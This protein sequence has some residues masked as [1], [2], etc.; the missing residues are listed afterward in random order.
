MVG[1]GSRILH[2]RRTWR[3]SIPARL[4]AHSTLAGS[5]WLRGREEE[6]KEEEKER[7][8]EERMESIESNW[9]GLDSTR[10]TT[11][12]VHFLF[13]Q[14]V[15]LAASELLGRGVR[16]L[17]LAALLFRYAKLRFRLP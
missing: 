10:H 12:L 1:L 2:V 3:K 8:A 4:E 9:P 13:H 7:K 14:L 17:E 16:H 11:H 6:E 15:F 5:E